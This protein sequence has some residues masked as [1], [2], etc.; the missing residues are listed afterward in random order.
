VSSQ[1]TEHLTT[2][3]VASLCSVTPN[4]V[5]KWIQAGKLTAHCTPGGHH[6]IPK[7]AVEAVLARRESHQQVVKASQP[8]QYCWEFNSQSGK[9]TG[10]CR[11]CIVYRSKTRR[12]YEMSELPAEVGHARKFCTISCEECDYFKLVKGQAPNVL[13]VTD[14]PELSQSIES[15]SDDLSFNTRVADCEYRCSMEIEDFRP[16]FVFLDCSLGESRTRDFAR[17]LY[18]DPRIPFVKVVMVGNGHKIPEECDK[19]VYALVQRTF[20]L[21]TIEELVMMEVS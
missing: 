8:I 5:L 18:E 20:T 9:I 15:S 21:E 13:I 12:C 14:Q 17:L 11:R 10:D 3:Q 16:D 7:T 19:L 6:R 1:G 4:T 2:G